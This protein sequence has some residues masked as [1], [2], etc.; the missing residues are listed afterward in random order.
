MLA[1]RTKKL[2]AI[3]PRSW[4]HPA[5]KAA[6]AAL[7]GVK[8]LDDVAKFVFGKTGEQSLRLLHIAS[9]VRVT[10]NQFPRV[11]QMMERTVDAFDWG[12]RPEV[13]VTQSP[14]FNAGV[15]GVAE[16]FVV[17]NSSVVSR[18]DDAE[19]ACVVA[20]EMGHIMSGHAAYKTLLWLLLNLSTNIAPAAELVIAPIVAALREWDRKSEL[21]ADRAG[22]LATQSEDPNYAVLMKMAGGDDVTQLNMND[23][24]AQAEEYESRKGLLD[25]IHKILNT[26]WESHPFPVIRLKELRSWAASGQ[27]RAIL[28]GNYLKRGFYEADAASDIKRGFDFYKEELAKGDDPLSTAA[29]S[30]GEGLNKLGEGI[31]EA[32]KGLF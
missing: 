4:E 19:L 31:G 25:G 8:G 17:L 6:L 32:L 16:P 3:D 15:Y 1:A 12:Y 22:L 28:D 27:Y 24:F 13:F 29:R 11:H 21:S 30:L 23:F 9:S 10:P 2:Y 14:F 20:H 18:L 7:R 26:V 5:D